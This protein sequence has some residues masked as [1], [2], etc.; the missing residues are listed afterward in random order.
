MSLINALMRELE[1]EEDEISTPRLKQIRRFASNMRV[2]LF[3]DHSGYVEVMYSYET[4]VAMK[5]LDL[6]GMVTDRFRTDVK[7][8]STTTRHISKWG[9]LGAPEISQDEL[10][11]FNPWEYMK[12]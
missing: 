10:D 11:R 8:S 7:W 2:G 12:N 1:E 9:C 3:Y 6:D 5:K 4:P